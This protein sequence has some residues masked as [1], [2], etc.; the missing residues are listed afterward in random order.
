MIE[1]ENPAYIF[2]NNKLIGYT[3]NLIDALQFCSNYD[4]YTWDLADH[5][6]IFDHLIL[7]QN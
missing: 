6:D 3:V 1:I 5:A 7:I 4:G 2:K